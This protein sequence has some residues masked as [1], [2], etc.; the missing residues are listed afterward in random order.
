MALA[1]ETRAVV[2]QY[3]YTD[4]DVNKGVKEFIRQLGECPVPDKT[5]LCLT[6]G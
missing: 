2:A 5:Q 6:S 4:E 3:E 1:V